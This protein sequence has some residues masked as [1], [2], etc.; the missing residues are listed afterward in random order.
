LLR[1]LRNDLAEYAR[2]EQARRLSDMTRS[3]Y[4]VPLYRSCLLSLRCSEMRGLI[5]LLLLR[6]LRNDFA[7]YTR[8]AG[9]RR[10][11]PS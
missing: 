9:C 5:A 10:R 4:M 8:D 11:R 7:K 3:Q 6:T 2:D 1:T